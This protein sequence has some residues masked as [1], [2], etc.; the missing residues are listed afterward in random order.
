MA[1]S[2]FDYSA[3]A[4]YSAIAHV[5]AYPNPEPNVYP[6]PNPNCIPSICRTH[7]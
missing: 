1:P 4:H 3:T 5:A 2:L 7:S 6:G